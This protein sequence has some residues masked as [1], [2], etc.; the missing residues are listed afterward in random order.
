[1][2]QGR[3]A[4][5]TTQ[6][7]LVVAAGRRNTSRSRDALATLFEAYWYPLYVFLRHKGHPAEEAEDLV[8]AFFARTLEKDTIA[9]ADPT[10]GRF[11][12]FL[13]TALT[14]FATNEFE[15]ARTQKRGGARRQV[16]LDVLEGEARYRLEPRTEET[17]E[18]LFERR[19]AQTL[20]QR[21]VT[22]LRDDFVRAGR[23]PLFDA[24]SP[25]LLGIDDTVPY[26]DLAARLGQNEPALRVAVHRLRKG[27]RKRLEAE[28][29]ET[30]ATQADVEAELQ[31]LRAAVE[32]G[33]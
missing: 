25:F 21:A 14:H 7:S 19:W 6:W 29:A 20:L 17:P 31:F 2:N 22:S 13:L 28:V 23:A 10:R 30:V 24:L 15:R 33:D 26:R 5:A 3:R 8:Q 9:R 12:N 32:A 4:F 27:L 18:R 1:M 16:R 11:R